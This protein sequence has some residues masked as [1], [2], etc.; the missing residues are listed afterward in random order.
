MIDLVEEVGFYLLEDCI[1][2]ISKEKRINLTI[3]SVLLNEKMV[4]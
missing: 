1:S 3:K 2:Y 4:E